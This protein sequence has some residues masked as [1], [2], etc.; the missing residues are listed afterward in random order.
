MK[1][2]MRTFLGLVAVM[3]AVAVVGAQEKPAG[4]KPVMT[5]DNRLDGTVLSVD[6]TAK[7]L[8]V[9][10]RGNVPREVT[11]TWDE[12]TRVTMRN[13]KSSLDEVKDGRR[14]IVQGKMGDKAFMATRIDVRDQG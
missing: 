3:F 5:K 7:T 2:A 14:V 9:R 13:K 12:K 8:Q 11:V 6:K 1:L 10:V 4:D